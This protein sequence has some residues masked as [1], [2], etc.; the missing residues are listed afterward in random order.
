MMRA[1]QILLSALRPG[2]TKPILAV[3]GRQADDERR[4]ALL[5]LVCRV[6]SF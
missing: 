5:R 6:V 3:G 4:H 1:V 2:H